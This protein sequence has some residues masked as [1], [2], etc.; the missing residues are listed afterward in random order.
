M[1]VYN[2]IDELLTHLQQR[3]YVVSLSVIFFSV[4]TVLTYIYPPLLPITLASL[5][6]LPYALLL[7]G[8]TGFDESSYHAW[9]PTLSNRT[10]YRFLVINLIGTVPIVGYLAF[11]TVATWES[12]GDVAFFVA[13]ASV[14]VFTW[15]QGLYAK[16]FYF[17]RWHVLERGLFVLLGGLVVISPAF[18]PLYLVYLN[19]IIGQFSFP[20]ITGFNRTH[21]KLP[22]TMLLILSGFVFV[23]LLA[24]I[25]PY[26][27]VTSVDPYA[28][29]FLLLCGYASNYFQPGIG[30]LKLGPR[31]YLTENNPM[32]LFMNAYKCGWLS[33]VDEQTVLRIGKLAEKYKLALNAGVIAIEVG[34]IFVLLT[35]EVAIAFAIATFLLHLSIFLLTG[36]NF[37]KWMAVNLGIVGGLLVA[38]PIPVTL[39][40]SWHWL[41]LSILFIGCS[42][43][44]MKPKTL[45]WLDS[46]YT[47]YYKL[48]G[49]TASCERLDL[50]PN[51]FAPYDYMFSQGVSG[52]FRFLGENPTPI[53]RECLGGTRERAFHERVVGA[54]SGE[55]PDIGQL[56][57]EFGAELHDEEKTT[58]LERLMRTYV[59]EGDKQRQFFV[60]SLTPPSEFYCAGID[61]GYSSD[62]S[63]IEKIVVDRI[64]GVWTD[65]DF[66]ETNRET[67]VEIKVN[68]SEQHT[69]LE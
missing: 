63:K 25:D 31:Y 50:D 21:S 37:W 44:W 34:I 24:A 13:I 10:N 55:K 9:S 20:E 18:V 54:F 14:I 67:V 62:I 43:A 69:T 45:G 65:E 2:D 3:K 48:E 41:A 59:D 49:I 60:D 46:P 22:Y 8:A 19:V 53:K 39:F 17:D 51:V 33:R 35:V 47:L 40:E 26:P 36:V 12:F 66:E 29:T 52:K 42:R 16:N 38:D 56:E 23:D 1:N 7:R 6:V 61:G 27:I 5:G 64:D 58:N 68:I 28:V 32:Y 15:S 4:L 11:D 30:K 57:R